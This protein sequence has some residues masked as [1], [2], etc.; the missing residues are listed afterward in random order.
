MSAFG[1]SDLSDDHKNL[2]YMNNPT[3]QSYIA[4]T[5]NQCDAEAANYPASWEVLRLAI[6]DTFT[7]YGLSPGRICP[8]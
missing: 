3:T 6:P 4:W 8:P 5:D 1:N 2:L 7:S